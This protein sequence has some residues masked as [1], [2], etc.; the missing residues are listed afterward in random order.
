MAELRALIKRM[1]YEVPV[2]GCTVGLKD[3]V[4][5]TLFSK[6][7]RFATG[8]YFIAHELAK[9]G[10]CTKDHEHQ[11]V[12]GYS[13]GEP[14]SVQ[15]QKYTKQLCA[16]ILRGLSLQY[17]VDQIMATS[18]LAISDVPSLRQQ[19]KRLH[20]NLGHA[21][22]DEMLRML[23][24]AGATPEILGHVRNFSCPICQQRAA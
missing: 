24:H 3:K 15:S 23:K 10:T 16:G 7:W 1:G 9:F 11:P 12:E 6:A 17:D 21:P 2:H 5:G 18:A 13:G 22:V 8:G 14:R 4:T 19:I 20:V